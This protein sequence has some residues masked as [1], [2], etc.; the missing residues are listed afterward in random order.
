MTSRTAQISIQFLDYW[1]A[2]TGASG[3]GDADMV[4][5]R[6]EWGCPAMPMS[7]VKGILR[8]TAETFGILDTKTCDLYFGE[9]SQE[10]IPTSQ[11]SAISF[12]GN[13][14]LVGSQRRWLGDVSN[15]KYRDSLYSNRKSTA[16]NQATGT[17]QKESLRSIEAVVPLTLVSNI[18][19][20]SGDLASNPNWIG[21]MDQICAMTS[22]LGKSVHDGFGR[23]IVTCASVKS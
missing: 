11:E 5:Y 14:L 15:R 20:I 22:Y 19:W 4:A 16:I 9:R 17:A 2:G 18:S 7:Q 8:E 12:V 10:G 3:R 6:D 23:A 21:S 1:H 13:A